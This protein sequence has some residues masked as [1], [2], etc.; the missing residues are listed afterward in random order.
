MLEDIYIKRIKNNPYDEENWMRL[1]LVEIMSPLE[2]YLSALKCLEEMNKYV[3][4]NADM[5]IVESYIYWYSYGCISDNLIER[6][7]KFETKDL[8][9][10]AIICYMLYLG[11]KGDIKKEKHYLYKSI[12]ISDK[13]VYPYKK[14][15]LILENEHKYVEAKEM[16][17]KAI[18]NVMHIFDG[19]SYHDFTD[20]DLYIAEYIT[21]THLSYINFEA[22]KKYRNKLHDKCKNN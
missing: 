17:D 8:D 14:L 18:G 11:S 4:E 20:K 21:G 2:D 6:L 19:K 13:F 15:A 5:L 22:L 1:C 7:I 16:I 3:K 10:N 9:K 12:Q